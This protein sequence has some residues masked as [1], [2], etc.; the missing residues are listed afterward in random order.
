MLVGSV[1]KSEK[2]MPLADQARLPGGQ[3][4]VQRDD[5]AK[6]AV[7]GPSLT[8]LSELASDAQTNIDII[9]NVNL[10]FSVNKDSGRIMVIVTDE[11]TGKVIREIPPSEFVKFAEKFDEMVGM[12]FDQ[13]G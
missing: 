1:T 12:I 7:Q 11:A 9:H 10:Q 4:T 6:K 13:K 5:N 3:E 8:E 2:I